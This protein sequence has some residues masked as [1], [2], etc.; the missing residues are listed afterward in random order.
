MKRVSLEVGILITFNTIIIVYNII[1]GIGI[2]FSE[3][4][5]CVN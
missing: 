5:T 1:Q 2:K 4:L 3:H